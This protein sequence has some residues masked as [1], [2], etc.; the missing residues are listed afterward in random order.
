MTDLDIDLVLVPVDGSD[1]SHEAV[2]YAIGIAEEYGAAVHA[3]YV[4]DE[5]VVRALESGDTDEADVADDTQSFTDSVIRRAEAVGVDHGNSIA[6]GFSTEVKTVHPGSVVLD[7]AEELE[8]DFIV[9]P[10]EPV[11][12]DPGQV[13]EK[14]AE[15]VL[16]YASQ[17]VLSV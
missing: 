13:L 17:P 9:I 12:G 7:T 16:L 3:L 4:L 6:Y 11:T 15:Y 5:E 10:R 1:A 14:A 8:A 2:D